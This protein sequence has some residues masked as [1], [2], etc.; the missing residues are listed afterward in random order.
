[1]ATQA[2]VLALQ[3]EGKSVKEIAEALKI[4]PNGVYNHLRR[5]GVP[6]AASRSRS[7]RRGRRRAVPAT[8][9]DTPPPMPA[10][11]T[12]TVPLDG[13]S[14]VDN[15]QAG[16]ADAVEHLEAEGARLRVELTAVD[17]QRKILYR[18]LIDLNKRR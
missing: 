17:D 4:R 8:A 12:L 18:T 2:E 15:I 14:L 13:A 3:K 11:T 10:P 16:I 6:A 7:A 1:M 9:G 5:A